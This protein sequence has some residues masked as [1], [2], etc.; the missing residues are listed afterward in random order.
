MTLLQADGQ[1]F[2]SAHIDRLPDI[3]IPEGGHGMF[4]T[5]HGFDDVA[6][7]CV[8]IKRR[9]AKHHGHP[10]RI[11]VRK[12]LKEDDRDH[13][14]LVEWIEARR[15]GYIRWAKKK[16]VAEGRDLTRIHGKF[17]TIYAAGSLANKFEILPLKKRELFE[18]ILKCEAD[19]VA[20]V[21]KEVGNPAVSSPSATAKVR[22]PGLS[23]MACRAR[24]AFGSVPNR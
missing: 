7:F 22:Q 12:L 6:A 16:I 8:E 23:R 9:A 14:G 5:L 21:A 3:P 4:E 2:D 20:F 11:F 13:E 17:A 1:Q 19:H 24:N 10:G 15:S 18:A